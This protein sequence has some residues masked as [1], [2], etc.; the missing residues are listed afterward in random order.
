MGKRL[1]LRMLAVLSSS[2]WA[3]ATNPATGVEPLEKAASHPIV[4]DRPGPDFFEGALMGNGGLGA[5]VTTRPDAVVLHFG[6][7]NV[8]DI[9]IAEDNKDKIGTFRDV[10]DKVAAIPADATSLESD[11]WYSEYLKMTQENYRKPYPRPFPCGS[12]LLGFDRRDVE[13]LGY[14]LDIATGVCTVN[15]LVGKKPAQLQLLAEMGGDRLWL[16]L[17]DTAGSP[18]PNCFDRVRLIPDPDA[19][20]NIPG[21]QVMNEPQGSTLSF[22]Q[23]LPFNEPVDNRPGEPHAKD[24]AF[25]LSARMGGALASTERLNWEGR[26][27]HMGPLERG[28]AS[29]EPFVAVVQL[30]EGLASDVMPTGGNPP[31]ATAERFDAARQSTQQ[32]WKDYWSR[33]SVALDDPLL[34]QVWYWNHYFLNCSAKPGVNCPGLFANW[35]YRNIGTAWHGDY[36]MNYNVQQPFW[37]P[38]SSNRVEKDLPYVELIERLL[39]LSQEWAKDYYGLRG[40]Y[41]PHSAYPV[42]MTTLPYPVPTWGWEIC[43]T[44]WA[45]QGLWWHYLYTM[46][47]DYLRQHAFGPIREATRFLADYMKRPEAHGGKWGDD[48][49]HV[50]PTVP[51]ELYGLK[52]GFK[53]NNDCLVDLTLIKFVMKAYAEAVRVLDVQKDEAELMGDVRDILDHFPDYP[54]AE[55]RFGK[56][57]VSVPGEHTEVVYNV[58]NSLMTVFPGEDHGL[59]SSKE[60]LDTL[61]NTYKNNQNEGGNDLV[62]LNLQAARIGMLDLDRF[63]RQIE[64]CLLPDGTCADMVLQV[65]GRY[66]DLTPYDFMR[67][68]GI[69]FENFG[70]PVVINECLMQSYD[71]TIRL[72]PN[73]PTARSASFQTLRAVGAFLV[74]A[75]CGGGG[76]E[77]VEIRSEAGTSLKVLNPWKNGARVISG[78]K[79]NTV[80]GEFIELPTKPGET[81]R[82][83]PAKAGRAK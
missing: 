77:Q 78:S 81:V 54:T 23:V 27:Q 1:F 71:G 45:V 52:P 75:S 31:E 57:F 68:M 40:A 53:Y 16:R 64:Y 80:E 3:D 9:R 4:R 24:R 14:H 17:T 69:W 10:F 43:E 38:F 44:P 20:K 65:H 67:P 47:R 32:V 58:P 73:W 59:G 48:R 22:R 29:G 11:R 66:D 19:P 25:R 76:V 18:I 12:L 5:V 7:N 46:D 83:L 55:S 49:Y 36:H 33:S 51:P 74:S 26:P 61:A 63:R 56:V 60:V 2:A 8:W 34:E 72:F 42:E 21:Y 35:S 13:L 50:F 15:L 82:L 79:E 37:L 30:D 6:H 39:P 70:L 41:F 28:F 62:F